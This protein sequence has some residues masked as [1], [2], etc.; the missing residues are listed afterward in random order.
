MCRSFQAL[1]WREKHLYSVINVWSLRSYLERHWFRTRG[2]R[3]ACQTF[4]CVLI[5]HNTV[6]YFNCEG[7]N[8]PS[9]LNSS[10]FIP[11]CQCTGLPR[12]IVNHCFHEMPIKVLGMLPL[13]STIQSVDCNGGFIF[14]SDLLKIYCLQ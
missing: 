2:A 3:L 7:A 6:E 12:L 10:A 11:Q 1:S 4:L 14:F 8:L 5:L 9:C 13:E